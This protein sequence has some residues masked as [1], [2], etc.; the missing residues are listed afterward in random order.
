MTS[1]LQDIVHQLEQALPTLYNEG[2]VDDFARDVYGAIDDLLDLGRRLL[3]ADTTTNYPARVQQEQELWAKLKVILRGHASEDAAR[4]RPI[5]DLA[6]QLLS[7]A[8]GVRPSKEGYLGFLAIVREQFG[9]LR[10]DY[11][12]AVAS[13]EPV[14]I[15]FSSGR[16][17]VE[18]AWAKNVSSSCSFGCESNPDRSFWI[19]DLLYLHDDKRYK[20]LPEE[21]ALDSQNTVAQWVAFLASVFRQYGHDVLT[22]RRGIFDELAAAQEARDREYVEQMDRQ[23]G[24][25]SDLK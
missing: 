17:Y 23:C 20:S 22:D 19:D 8:Q 2:Q 21:L 16:I 5:F 25:G 3:A 4:Y 11:G 7:I 9:F 1:Q 12:F 15:R 14:K 18:L 13:E 24:I 10:A 6:E